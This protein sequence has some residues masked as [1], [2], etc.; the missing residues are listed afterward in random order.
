MTSLADVLTSTDKRKQV[1]DDCV[2][3]LDQEV[4]DKGGLSGIAIKG[5]FKTIQGISPGFVRNVVNDL[6]PEF[7]KAADPVFQEAKEKSIPV[8]RHFETEAGRVA[9]ALLAI[10]D[11]RAE[12]TK[13][14][15]AKKLYET[16]RGTAKKH[17]ESAMPRV[18]K[19][20]EKHA[21]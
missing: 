21:V 8:S 9:D 6:L 18:G 19:L 5:A 12:R 20:I 3:V 1:V 2:V 7:A 10:T 4:A 17:V 15:S 14:T 11:R 16:L 13:Y